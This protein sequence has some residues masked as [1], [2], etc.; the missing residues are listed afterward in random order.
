[1]MSCVDSARLIRQDSFDV[2]EFVLHDAGREALQLQ[3]AG[4]A[5]ACAFR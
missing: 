4:M 5:L 2:I 3:L 1:M